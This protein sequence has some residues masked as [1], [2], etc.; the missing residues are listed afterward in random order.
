MLILSLGENCMPGM[1]LS[2][3]GIANT[4]STPYTY[5]R[6]N[7]E[8][9]L[10]WEKEEYKDFLEMKYIMKKEDSSFPDVYTETLNIVK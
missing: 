4:W 7:I 3:F 9:S 6:S 2:R 10:L 1:L 5:A 8:Q